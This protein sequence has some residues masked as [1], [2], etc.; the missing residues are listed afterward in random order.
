MKELQ[1]ISIWL[2]SALD[3]TA[4]PEIC[5]STVH[6]VSTKTSIGSVIS[7]ET[8]STCAACLSRDVGMC[9]MQNQ[10][11][12]AAV[13]VFQKIRTWL[14]GHFS[15]VV[16]LEAEPTHILEQSFPHTRWSADRSRKLE[17]KEPAEF[18]AMSCTA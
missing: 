9:S 14:D 16:C 10:L 1:A 18:V 12:T 3:L 15:T 7:N 5:S 6:M 8:T 13:A 2:E 4:S 11:F 17:T